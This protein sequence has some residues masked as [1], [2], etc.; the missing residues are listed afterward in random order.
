MMH[1]E[2]RVA[3]SGRSRSKD[4]YA[5]Y[6]SQTVC[7]PDEVPTD[8][9]FEDDGNSRPYRGR[10]VECRKYSEREALSFLGKSYFIFFTF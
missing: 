3:R 4:T 2:E 1:H 6:R 8:D 5:W 9:E 10:Y 7:P